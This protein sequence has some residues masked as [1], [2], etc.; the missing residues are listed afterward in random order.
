M[1]ESSKSFLLLIFAEQK[2]ALLNSEYL[3]VLCSKS[4]C[5]STWV[6]REIKLFLQNHPRENVLTVLAEGEPQDVIPR[7]L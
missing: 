5:L 6:E 3:I 4:T 2:E 7:I 1:D